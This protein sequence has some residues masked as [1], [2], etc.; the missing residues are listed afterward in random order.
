MS[1][2]APEILGRV[3]AVSGA[4]RELLAIGQRLAEARSAV[5]VQGESG[6]LLVGVRRG[7]GAAFM[8]LK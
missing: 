2:A 1:V 6:Q 4:M 5:L 7:N 8:V 3:V